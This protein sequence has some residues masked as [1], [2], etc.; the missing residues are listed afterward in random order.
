MCSFSYC[1]YNLR[2]FRGDTIMQVLRTYPYTINRGV[3]TANPYYRDPDS[4][5]TEHAPQF[6]PGSAER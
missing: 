3:I 5:L 1:L 6:L 4:W 2:K